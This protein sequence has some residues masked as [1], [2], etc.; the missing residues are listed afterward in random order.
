LDTVRK[1]A[2]RAGQIVRNLLS[3][4]RRGNPDRLAVDLNEIVKATVALRGYHL[5]QRNISLEASLSGRPLTVLANREEIQQVVLNL[6][7]NAEQAM[8][9]AGQGARIVV[10]TGGDGRHH[11]IEVQ[12]DGPGIGPE[13]RGRI[14]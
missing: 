10:R 1:E 8:T 9:S 6:V 5:Q 11:Y 3:F 7:L 2:A 4:V 12:D 13:I 14:F